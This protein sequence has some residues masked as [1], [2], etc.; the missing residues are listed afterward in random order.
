MRS[1]CERRNG[2]DAHLAF[3]LLVAVLLSAALAL[4]GNRPAR[5]RLCAA[6]YTFLCSP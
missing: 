2:A 3:T 4:L 5:E 6:T 1:N